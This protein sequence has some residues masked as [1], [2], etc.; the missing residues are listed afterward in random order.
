MGD[1][2]HGADAAHFFQRVLDQ[3]LGLRVDICRSLVQNHHAGLVDDGAGKAEQL[4]LTCREVVAA[5]PHFLV[6]AMVQLVDEVIGVDVVTDAADLL[7]RDA[8]L[9]QDDV[10]AD[11][12]G[13]EEHVLQ[14][15]AKMAA[16]RGNLDLADVD[17]VNQ[18]LTLLELIIAADERQN[19]AFAAAGGA[20]KGHGLPRVD[21]EGHALQHPLAGDVTEPDVAELNL[22]LHLVQLDGAGGVHQ[23]RLNVHDGEHLFRG[24]QR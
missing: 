10:A 13:E 16:Q 7:V 3:Q 17:A 20:D 15:L 2:E 21:V 11:G 14:H 8:L 5:L 23:F 1:H 9:P 18:N 6:Q 22:A 12:A 4:P 19:C 24:G